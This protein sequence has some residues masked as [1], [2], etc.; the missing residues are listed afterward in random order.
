VINR[1]LA[2]LVKPTSA[3]NSDA[4]AL[5]AHVG[6]GIKLKRPRCEINSWF[7]SF[8]EVVDLS[9]KRELAIRTPLQTGGKQ[10]NS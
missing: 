5:K 8:Q 1:K 4:V 6:A 7:Q 2:K 10:G 9:I 3:Q